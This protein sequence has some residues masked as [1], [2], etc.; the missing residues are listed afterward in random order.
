MALA[1]PVVEGLRIIWLAALGEGQWFKLLPLHL[2]GTQVLFI[3]L[4]ILTKKQVLQDYIWCTSIIGGITA[5][6]YPTGIVDT[7]PF[8]H[9]Q[10][11]QSLILHLLLILVPFLMWH[12]N[13]YR[14]QPKNFLKVMGI[15]FLCAAC[16]LLVDVVW[17][18]NYMFLIEIPQVFP[19]TWIF[20]TFGYVGYWFILAL[21]LGCVCAVALHIPYKKEGKLNHDK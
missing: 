13:H 21:A 2:C 6:V 1:V 4:A 10:T 19:L 3:P 7:Y 14:P 8:F 17:G 12:V 9:F 11:F 15:L 18:Q 5:I 20:S 16:A